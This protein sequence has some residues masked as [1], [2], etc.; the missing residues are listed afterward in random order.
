MP[1]YNFQCPCCQFIWDGLVPM[2]R[3]WDEHPI[4]PDCG[5]A[6]GERTLAELTTING[7]VNTEQ[8]WVNGKTVFQLHPNDP[9]RV[10][11]S[12][13]QCEEVYRKNGISLETGQIVDEKKF[14]REYNKHLRKSAP[15]AEARWKKKQKAQ[16]QAG[17][18]PDPRKTG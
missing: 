18:T 16:R 9:D 15:L 1:F 3:C 11:T 10:V 13:R 14:H 8:D 12:Q 4:C 6:G 7:C 2:A 17:K 5:Q